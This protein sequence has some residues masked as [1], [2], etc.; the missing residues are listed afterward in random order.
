M[1]PVGV[2]GFGEEGLC[3]ALLTVVTIIRAVRLVLSRIQ[4]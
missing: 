2:N 3:A 4:L 1:L